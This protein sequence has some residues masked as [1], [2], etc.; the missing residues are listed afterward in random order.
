MASRR[1]VWLSGFYIFWVRRIRSILKCRM[2][3]IRGISQICEIV[4]YILRI[5]HVH[6]ISRICEI[7]FC[8]LRIRCIRGILRVRIRRIRGILKCRIQSARCHVYDVFYTCTHFMQVLQETPSHDF[9]KI[10]SRHSTYT[11]FTLTGVPA[12][13]PF[14]GFFADVCGC[15]SRPWYIL[16]EFFFEIF[17]NP[18]FHDHPV[19]KILRNLYSKTLL[20]T[21]ILS[22]GYRLRQDLQDIIRF[23]HVS[24][25]L[26]HWPQHFILTSYYTRPLCTQG[27]RLRQDLRD[28]WSILHISQHPW[29]ISPNTI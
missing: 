16:R 12:L 25:P 11:T 19:H 28:I 7:V 22:Q 8:I 20:Y 29:Y 6:G 27:Y 9:S 10:A 14:P 17:E 18:T 26:I 23:V 4:F 2:R 21:T 5:R 3:R 13:L 1:S 15:L 24:T